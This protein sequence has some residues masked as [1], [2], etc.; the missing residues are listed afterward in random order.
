MLDPDQSR[1]PRVMSRRR[2]DGTMESGALHNMFPYLGE[3][4]A[5]YNARFVPKTP[6]VRA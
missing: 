4:E 1:S 5:A 3:K 6:K 2:E